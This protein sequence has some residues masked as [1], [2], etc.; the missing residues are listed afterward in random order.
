MAGLKWVFEL[1]DKLSAP[2][3]KM[4]SNL[5]QLGT[6]MQKLERS[7]LHAESALDRMSRR[8]VSKLISGELAVEGIK[9]LGETVIDLGKSLLETAMAAAG[10]KSQSLFTLGALTKSKLEAA[11][12]FDWVNATAGKAG[13]AADYIMQMSQGFIKS[14]ATIPEMQRL[15]LLSTDVASVLGKESGAQWASTFARMMQSPNI[16]LREMKPMLSD[17]GIFEE[18][19]QRIGKTSHIPLKKIRESFS[20]MAP[21]VSG[22]MKEVTLTAIWQATQ[23]KISGGV[24]ATTTEETSRKLSRSLQRIKTNWERL[25]EDVNLSFFA[26]KLGKIADYLDPAV[27]S[28][29]RLRRVFE[30]LGLSVAAFGEGFW[31]SLRPMVSTLDE[32]ASSA[33]K[34]KLEE[35][36][37]HAGEEVGKFL[38][39]VKDLAKSLLEINEVGGKFLDKAYSGV[40]GAGLSARSSI[41][42]GPV[43]GGLSGGSAVL[44][45]VW[46][47]IAKDLRGRTAP[48]IAALATGPEDVG[49]NMGRALGSASLA[50][51]DEQTATHSPSEEWEKR[52]R[53]AAEGYQRGVDF[54]GDGSSS[55]ALARRGGANIVIH[56][57][58]TINVTTG[59]DVNAEEVA[60]R[61]AELSLNQL[62]A[63]LDTAAQQVGGL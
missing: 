23:Q 14:G 45:S 8:F 15:L 12:I 21:A 56:N 57:N 50:G 16:M 28:G 19:I 27:E 53:Y 42:N 54:G 41:V 22:K 4:S 9:K 59:P 63:A 3:A 46:D 39:T 17:L 6:K 36:F 48:S 61:L 38:V 29:G 49:L 40:I 13:F 58:P 37:R 30:T 44:S 35:K 32:I 24:I 43:L 62:Q 47:W 7:S 26:D 55:T 5:E 2:A 1:Q 10:F 20:D 18:V 52:G 25:F 60:Q 31:G 34:M 51:Y 11:E 33:D